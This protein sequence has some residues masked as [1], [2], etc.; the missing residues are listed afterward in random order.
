MCLLWLYNGVVQRKTTLTAG[1][2]LVFKFFTHIGEECFQL[3][4]SE[5]TLFPPA[6]LSGGDLSEYFRVRSVR[7]SW[8]PLTLHVTHSL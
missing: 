4:I 8:P 3:L 2:R 5:L 1:L 7:L 6:G